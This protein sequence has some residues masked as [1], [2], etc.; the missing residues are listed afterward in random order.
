MYKLANKN[1]KLEERLIFVYDRT[2]QGYEWALETYQKLQSYQY[3]LSFSIVSDRV[4]TITACAKEK[5]LKVKE[6]A[7]CG[8]SC[9]D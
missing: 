4:M 7:W 8:F 9:L 2:L 6:L 1:F 5:V 3:C